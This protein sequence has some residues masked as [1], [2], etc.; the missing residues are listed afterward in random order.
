MERRNADGDA[1]YPYR[2][3]QGHPHYVEVSG[4]ILHSTSIWTTRV[5]GSDA[6]APVFVAPDL[7]PNAWPIAQSMKPGQQ[8]W[9]S[10]HRPDPDALNCITPAQPR[11]I[12]TGMRLNDDLQPRQVIFQWSSI[13]G[14]GQRLLSLCAKKRHPPGFPPGFNWVRKAMRLSEIRIQRPGAADR[15]P[16]RSE[17]AVD[18]RGRGRGSWVA[19][20][21]FGGAKLPRAPRHPRSALG[22]TL[23]GYWRHTMSER[24]HRA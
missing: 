1:H 22:S 18:L 23:A 19:P 2:A 13:A 7:N 12:F 4:T 20:P 3:W 15:Q 9:R 24:F 14:A 6:V 10:Q 16:S 5:F 17:C 11:W 8:W 21:T